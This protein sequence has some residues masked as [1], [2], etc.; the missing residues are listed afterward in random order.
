MIFVLLFLA[1]LALFLGFRLLNYFLVNM[2]NI[3]AFFFELSS[4][5]FRV[6]FLIFFS[7]LLHELY[8]DFFIRDIV[9]VLFYLLLFL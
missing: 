3:L 5:L 4:H 1:F 9:L 6:I 2:R 8:H 7:L